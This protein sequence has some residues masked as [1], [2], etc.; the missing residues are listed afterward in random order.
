MDCFLNNYKSIAEYTN[1]SIIG[2][3][4]NIPNNKY[5][6]FLKFYSQEV[7]KG[8][9]LYLTE[10]HL[11]DKGPIIIDFDFRYSNNNTIDSPLTLTIMD[12]IVKHINSIINSVYG[13]DDINNVCV[14]LKRPVTYIDTKNNQVKDGIHIHF[15][16]LVTSYEFQHSLRNKY[17]KIMEKDL[18][19]IP[20]INSLEDIYDKSVIGCNPWFLYGSTKK[21][22]PAY[23]IIKIYNCDTKIDELTLFNKIKLLS[24]RNKNYD[25]YKLSVTTDK[26]LKFIEKYYNVKNIKNTKKNIN[27]S[28]KKN[29][30][31]LIKQNSNNNYN[32]QYNKYNN[33]D[34]DDVEKLLSLLSSSYCDNHDDWLTIGAMLYNYSLLYKGN[35][36]DLLNIWDKWSKKSNKY[37]ENCCKLQW[38]KFKPTAEKKSKVGKLIKYVICDNI[39]NYEK[40]CEYKILKYA[41]FLLHEPVSVKDNYSCDN[42]YYFLLNNKYCPI[43]NTEHA[44]PCM[45]IEAC[46]KGIALKCNNFESKC[47]NKL[48]P[49]EGYLD[50]KNNEKELLFINYI[51]NNV[52]IINNGVEDIDCLEFNPDL[53][54]L[55]D[56]KKL[57]ILLLNG[58]NNTAS[59]IAEIIY[60]LY[61][62]TIYSH[63]KDKEWYEFNGHKW[64]K[65][66]GIR[67]YVKIV[68]EH[69][70][71]IL[72]KFQNNEN[73]GLVKKISN[74]RINLGNTFVINNIITELANLY[75]DYFPEF[76]S[77]LDKNKYLIGFNNGVYDLLNCEF[78]DGKYSDYITMSVGY[79]YDPNP[80]YIEELYQIIDQ[81]L[82][83]IKVRD[84]LMTIFSLCLSGV[85]LQKIFFLEGTGSNGKSLLQKLLSKTLNDYMAIMNTSYIVSKRQG[86]NECSPQLFK[87]INTRCLMFS[88]PNKND[89]LN[90]GIIKELTGSDTLSV[91]TLHKEPI[92]Y[93]T[94]F[95]IFVLTNY[96]PQIDGTDDAIWRRV[97]NIKFKSRFVENPNK[98]NPNEYKMDCKLY[99]KLDIYK[100]SFIQILL[101][102]WKKYKENNYK[103]DEPSEVLEETKK[104]KEENNHY[105]NFC[106][107]FIKKDDS[108]NIVWNDLYLAYKEWHFLNFK[109]TAQGARKC[110]EEFI[111]HYFLV[112]E[113]RFRQGNSRAYGWKGYSLIKELDD[114][115]DNDS[116][117]YTCAFSD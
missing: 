38:K 98:N 79:D 4:W 63:G 88:E 59:D 44:I 109:E 41:S 14:L 10:K 117:S 93:E 31:Q 115:I 84:Y 55:N 86:A 56:D 94:T 108:S 65:D 23:E 21:N 95:K 78:R 102:Y 80:P 68:K 85:T 116:D 24:I 11:P 54:T 103:I 75:K 16:Y 111:K 100:T 58:L 28:N 82:P 90:E 5:N 22:I 66:A 37:S 17:I 36:N 101:S 9:E 61:P 30:T 97:V 13:D 49:I 62:N 3:K 27:K 25:K 52:T 57:N 1:T 60:Y 112:D 33:M 87:T 105:K 20:Y 74:I 76:E 113:T 51:T 71:K 81:I 77:K 40:F 39:N 46:V 15:P 47:I 104:Y 107:L 32:V 73:T 7:K 26:Y 53:I 50:Y 83:N 42:S 96:L 18:E 8:N 106:N 70:S 114:K 110:K 6:E 92:K 64:T 45:Y 35:P 19:N 69:Y 2:G 99:D 43:A 89:V 48:Y 12:K 29:N 34:I 67:K 91:R 72:L